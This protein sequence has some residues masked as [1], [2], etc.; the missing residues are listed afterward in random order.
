[1]AMISWPPQTTLSDAMRDHYSDLY[2]ALVAMLGHQKAAIDLLHGNGKLT[3]AERL[4][5]LEDLADS[6]TRGAIDF[7]QHTSKM[8]AV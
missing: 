7:A 5:L 1:M 3:C 4:G 8:A 6:A 2:T